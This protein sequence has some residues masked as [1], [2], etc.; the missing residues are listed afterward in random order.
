[1]NTYDIFNIHN[2]DEFNQMALAIYHFQ[3]EHNKVYGE[4]LKVSHHYDKPIQHYSEIV[5]L[6]IEFFKTQKVIVEQQT[7]QL[8]FESSGTTGQEISRHFVVDAELYRQSFL[9]GF[10]WFYGDPVD[11]TFLALLPS[12]L[13]KPNSSLVFMMKGL[14][15][16]SE[17]PYNGFILNEVE[18]LSDRIK[19]AKTWRQGKVL[20]MGVSYALW[21]LAEKYPQNLQGIIVMETG[22]MKGRRKEITRSQLH[23]ILCQG[24]GLEKIH[25]EYGMT[26]MLSQAYSQ[27][28]GLFKTPPWLRIYFTEP[29]DPFSL[30]KPGKTGL[31]NVVDLA[32]IYSCSFIAT[33]DLGRFTTNGQFEI[34]GRHDLAELRGCNLMLW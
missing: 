12:Y 1:M 32:N 2:E 20:L 34:I 13:E 9:K 31:I 27:G 30:A 18:N 26:E 3:K 19:K 33:S 22:G 28:E 4:F 7:P 23:E 24:F 21:D 6:P 11:W 16:A 14:M 29:D 15:E 10:T 8:V 5:S 25:S 17:S